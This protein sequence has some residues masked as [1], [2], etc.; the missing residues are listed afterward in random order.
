MDNYLNP[1]VRAELS[2]LSDALKAVVSG[3][4]VDPAA[5][6]KVLESLRDMMN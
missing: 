4:N 2:E 1:N 3:P 5:L 6:N